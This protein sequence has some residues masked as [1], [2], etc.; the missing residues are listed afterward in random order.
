MNSMINLSAILILFVIFSCSTQPELYSKRSV[1]LHKEM[2]KT[3]AR[4]K[5]ELLWGYQKLEDKM[6][7]IIFMDAPYR[8]PSFSG[9]INNLENGNFDYWTK[10]GYIVA[11]LS[12]PGQGNSE[13]K[14]DS[15]G[16]YS[17]ISI[18]QALSYLLKKNIIDSKKIVIVGSEKAVFATSYLST[19][20]NP[21]VHIIVDPIFRIDNQSLMQYIKGMNS[22]TL[23]THGKNNK[24]VNESNLLEFYQSLFFRNNKTEIKV[25]DQTNKTPK[26]DGDTIIRSFIEK[27]MRE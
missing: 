1:T 24:R 20:I 10:N 7:L 25:F 26:A 15:L 4:G 11:A 8:E 14:D 18:H 5:I 21:R 13:S 9:A 12:L 23:I 19:K 22:A 3:K 2:I 6:P 27:N 17:Q 16:H